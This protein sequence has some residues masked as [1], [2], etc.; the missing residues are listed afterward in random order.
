MNTEYTTTAS[1]NT[2]GRVLTI[3]Q[4]NEEYLFQRL[5]YL[6][7]SY[8]EQGNIFL[9]KQTKNNPEYIIVHK[10]DFE[11]IK[12]L[13]PNRVLTDLKECEERFPLL[14]RQEIFI[15]GENK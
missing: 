14:H 13:L 5:Y 12:I 10:D 4:L 9:I 11:W 2:K 1:D 8:L 15:S 6:K 3:K 7:T